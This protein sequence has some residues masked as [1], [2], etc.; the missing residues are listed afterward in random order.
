VFSKLPAR[1]KGEYEIN[2][3]RPRDLTSPEFLEARAEITEQ[4]EVVG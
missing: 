2:L 1:I 4:C 3:P